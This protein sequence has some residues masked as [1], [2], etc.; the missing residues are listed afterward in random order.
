MRRG[1]TLE[2]YAIR[3]TPYAGRLFLLVDTNVGTVSGSCI[4]DGGGG[5]AAQAG[6]GPEVTDNG[7]RR[8]ARPCTRPCARP[9]Q[10]QSG[11]IP[12]GQQPEPAKPL[13]GV[14]T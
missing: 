3:E 10:T 13:R 9:T 14:G 1:R 12:P 8:L 4:H 2:P 7:N 6:D 5:G 11:A